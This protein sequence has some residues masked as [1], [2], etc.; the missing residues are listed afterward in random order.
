MNIQSVPHRKEIIFPVTKSSRLTGT[1]EIFAVY[2]KTRAKQKS[3]MWLKFRVPL[4]LRLSIYVTTD[5]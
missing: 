3:V 5:I 4:P 1:A 2:F